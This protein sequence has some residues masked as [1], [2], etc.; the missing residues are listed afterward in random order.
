ML[1][2]TNLSNHIL[3]TDVFAA[4]LWWSSSTIIINNNDFRWTNDCASLFIIAEELNNTDVI[5]SSFSL[6]FIQNTF[7]VNGF[8]I[9]YKYNFL[10]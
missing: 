8:Y 7:S 9:C 4:D 10:Y 5:Y 1:N 2:N 3:L 6:R